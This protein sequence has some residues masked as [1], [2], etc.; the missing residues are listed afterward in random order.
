VLDW[1]IDAGTRISA[2][3]GGLSVR[4]LGSWITREHNLQYVSPYFWQPTTG[5]DATYWYEATGVDSGQV[6]ENTVYRVR[7]P[8]PQLG[9]FPHISVKLNWKKMT[10]SVALLVAAKS[11]YMKHSRI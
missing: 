2:L 1:L 8:N 4:P 5:S 3:E 11:R 7:I 10:D 6:I 9:V